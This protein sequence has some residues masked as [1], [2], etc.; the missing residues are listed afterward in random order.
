M[1]KVHL[2][3]PDRYHKALL[4]VSEE[5]GNIAKVV[6]TLRKVGNLCMVGGHKNDCIVG[7]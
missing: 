1:H 2:I 6:Q 5:A 7:V 4:K 3:A